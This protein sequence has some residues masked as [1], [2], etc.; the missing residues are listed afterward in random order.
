MPMLAAS[1]NAVRLDDGEVVESVF[2]PAGDVVGLVESFEEVHV[3]P[4]GV[5]QSFFYSRWVRA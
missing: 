1:E 5:R 3:T 4:R 2:I